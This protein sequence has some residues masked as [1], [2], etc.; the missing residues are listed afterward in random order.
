MNKKKK[1][2]EISKVL[3][4][5]AK[6][7]ILSTREKSEIERIAIA[8][9]ELHPAM[10]RKFQEK[11]NR[12]DKQVK[13]YLQGVLRGAKEIIQ[14]VKDEQASKG[15]ILEIRNIRNYSYSVKDNILIVEL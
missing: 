10:I 14:D 2:T 12:S 8:P 6:P 3:K 15:Q 11:Y 7:G 4:S 1:S 13:D 9:I 5:K